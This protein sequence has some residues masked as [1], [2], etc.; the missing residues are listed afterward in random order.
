MSVGPTP[1][2]KQLLA[3]PPIEFIDP[4]TGE[5]YKVAPKKATVDAAYKL[6]FMPASAE[7]LDRAEAVDA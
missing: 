7:D 2:A 3:T 6:G 5:Y 4:D 1:N